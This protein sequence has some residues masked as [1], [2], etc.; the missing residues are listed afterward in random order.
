MASND[1]ID[2]KLEAFKAHMEDILR[3]LFEEFRLGQSES[4]KR[5]QHEESSYHKENQSK[6]GDQAQDS[7]YP[8]MRVTFPDGKMETQ[9]EHHCKKGRL[10]VIEMIEYP[11]PK[12][13][14]L[15]SEEEDAEEEPQSTISTVHALAGYTNP[16]T[17]KI[18]EFLKH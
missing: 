5:S 11:K 2:V 10:L 1:I 3:A 4:P 9:S 16:Y 7:V 18:D 15:E 6:K 8:C 12:D 13:V 14:N 17:M